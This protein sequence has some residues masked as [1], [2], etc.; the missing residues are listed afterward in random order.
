M[1]LHHSRRARLQLL[2]INDVA[3]RVGA[4]IREAVEIIRHFPF[5]G[6]LGSV[7]GTREWI[8]RRMPYVIVYEIKPVKPDELVILGIFHGQEDRG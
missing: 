2:A 7:A 5:A 3:A 8:V 6:R 1:I 4:Q